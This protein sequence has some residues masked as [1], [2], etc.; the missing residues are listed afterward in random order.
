MAS[1]SGS[2]SRLAFFLHGNGGGNV[3][4]DLTTDGSGT[5]PQPVQG[6][7]N[8]EIF[9]TAPGTVAGGYQ[10]SAF[11]PGATLVN[12][13]IVSNVG[14]TGV[15][16]ALL[17]GSYKVVD[18]TG[19]EAIQII[20]SSNGGDSMTVVGSAGDTIIG[21]AIAG[22]QQLVDASGKNP[23][24]DPGPQTILG[25]SGPMTVLAGVGDSIV[26]GSGDMLI[27]GGANDTIIGG[28]GAMTVQGG[29][30][31]SIVA[32]TGEIISVHGGHGHFG[33]RQDG[34]DNDTAGIT[35]LDR[36]H[37]SSTVTG[38][39]TLTDDIQSATAVGD[40]GQFLGTSHSTAA[41]T[42]LNFVD[43]S[44]MVLAGVTDPSKI[45]FTK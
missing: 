32:G 37:G 38:F 23:L 12:N 8:I 36:G 42:T 4:L 20:G 43:G 19:N 17:T 24:A 35:L 5:R 30:D 33:H 28:S 41:G 10:G 27:S 40:D 6:K 45:D 2:G 34:P 18:E 31:D 7:L 22:A 21:S 9:T 44:T 39:N 26:G 15:T 16:E 3:N 14:Q 13:Y 1:V 11:I 29:V 25:G